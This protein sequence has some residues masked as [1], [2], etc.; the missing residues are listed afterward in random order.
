M[1]LINFFFVLVSFMLL[2]F[3]M[4]KLEIRGKIWAVVFCVRKLKLV[5][6]YLSY[7]K[8][9][10]LI[11]GILHTVL[12][13]AS[14]PTWQLIFACLVISK[15]RSSSLCFSVFM[16]MCSTR[17]GVNYQMS[18]LSF[19]FM[20]CLFVSLGMLQTFVKCNFSVLE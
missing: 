10:T 8:N 3:V 16:H 18:M 14:S 4:L 19:C 1:N 17:A 5:V 6:P 13:D 20:P 11:M 2:Q 7:Q 15:S 12:V 9:I